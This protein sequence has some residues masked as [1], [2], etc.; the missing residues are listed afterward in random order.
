MDK[1]IADIKRVLEEN[2]PTITVEESLPPTE[3]KDEAR[4]KSNPD[5]PITK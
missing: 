1:L 4:S 2:D 5:M 3:P